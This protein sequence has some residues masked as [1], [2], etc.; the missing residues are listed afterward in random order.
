MNLAHRS[1]TKV[2]DLSTQDIRQ[3]GPMMR[4]SGIQV[5]EPW[6][7]TRRLFR[8]LSVEVTHCL[9]LDHIGMGG[10]RRPRDRMIGATCAR[11]CRPMR[12]SMRRRRNYTTSKRISTRTSA[13]GRDACVTLSAPARWS[14][15]VTA[16]HHS[17]AF[18]R[19]EEEIAARFFR[20]DGGCWLLSWPS[21]RNCRSRSDI[22]AL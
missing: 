9:L 5:A 4:S 1:P 10:T 20:E 6:G 17:Q 11:P 7:H 14:V 12:S 3:F 15:D 19:L 18:L 21:V 8:R 22:S 16:L 13:T 2:P